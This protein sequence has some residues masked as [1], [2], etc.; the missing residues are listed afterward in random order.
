MITYFYKPVFFYLVLYN[1]T[2]FSASWLK[3]DE[4]NINEK[5]EPQT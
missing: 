3:F 1:G 5:I 2:D 4:K